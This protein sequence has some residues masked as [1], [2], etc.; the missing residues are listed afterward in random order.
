MSWPGRRLMGR[1]LLVWW[2]RLNR[3]RRCSKDWTLSRCSS[4]WQTRCTR[5]KSWTGQLEMSCYN[6][7]TL[8]R[9]PTSKNCSRHKG[10]TSI[11]ETRQWSKESWVMIRSWTSRASFCS[12]EAWQRHPRQVLSKSGAIISKV[13][14][15]HTCSQPPSWRLIRLWLLRPSLRRAKW[16]EQKSESCILAMSKSKFVLWTTSKMYAIE[17]TRL[18][19]SRV[20]TNWNRLKRTWQCRKRA[21]KSRS[22]CA[23]KQS[24]SKNCSKEDSE[25]RFI[26]HQ[27][28]LE[29]P[30]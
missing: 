22:M 21:L 23:M 16:S 26:Q 11:I 24:D 17:Q 8:R 29:P 20:S 9:A 6:K 12:R 28:I 18:S 1:L 2:K 5:K 25:F 4:S 10:Q 19:R 27:L 30:T 13:Y 14:M 15:T 7:W 3:I